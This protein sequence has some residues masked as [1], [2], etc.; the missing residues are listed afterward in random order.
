MPWTQ[1]LWQSHSLEEECWPQYFH[2]YLDNLYKKNCPSALITQPLMLTF[3]FLPKKLDVYIFWSFSQQVYYARDVTTWTCLTPKNLCSML[4]PLKRPPYSSMYWQPLQ[5][6]IYLYVLLFIFA[7]QIH[8]QR[9]HSV[10]LW[11][12]LGTVYTCIYWCVQLYMFVNSAI[13]YLTCPKLQ[14]GGHVWQSCECIRDEGESIYMSFLCLQCIFGC[15]FNSTMP[16]VT[17]LWARLTELWV[18]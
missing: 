7:G 8:S 6:N 13:S 4:S 17:K 12:Q 1:S 10:T 15:I 9:W 2:F 11:L 3:T 5:G 16:Q 14:N 18:H